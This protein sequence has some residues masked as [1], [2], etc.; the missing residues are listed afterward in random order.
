VTLGGNNDA[1]V[2][3]NVGPKQRTSIADS[4]TYKGVPISIATAQVFFVLEDFI[5]SLLWFVKLSDI[6][7]ISLG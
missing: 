1:S 5:K 2:I 4:V 3:T 6:V 7:Y